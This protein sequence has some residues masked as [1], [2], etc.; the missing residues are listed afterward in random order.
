MELVG[1]LGLELGGLGLELVGLRVVW[2]GE[3]GG[4]IL[5]LV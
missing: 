1:G 2:A 4:T 3:M 5:G